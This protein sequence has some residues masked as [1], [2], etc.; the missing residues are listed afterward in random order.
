M[1]FVRAFLLP[2]DTVILHDF[3]ESFFLGDERGVLSK[4]TSNQSFTIAKSDWQQNQL[5]LHPLI[6]FRHT[7]CAALKSE[8]RQSLFERNAGIQSP[9]ATSGKWHEVN[10]Q[11]RR[12]LVHM[13]VS[14]ENSE[15]G[16]P[17]LKALIILVQNGLGKLAVLG[18][19]A[20]VSR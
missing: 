3:S 18:S 8:S 10:M 4:R 9:L 16:I 17:I 1:L 6:P 7:P 11:M 5:S 13:Q 12:C 14:R 19:R 2:L 15:R 20:H